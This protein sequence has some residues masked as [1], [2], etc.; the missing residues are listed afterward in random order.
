MH[1]WHSVN[2]KKNYKFLT[3]EN[4]DMM[5]ESGGCDVW[6]QKQI[7]KSNFVENP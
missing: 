7:L 2:F 3:L 6:E 1:N 4:L 5:S